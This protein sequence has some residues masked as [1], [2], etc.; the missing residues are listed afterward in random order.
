MKK[1]CS[2]VGAGENKSNLSWVKGSSLIIAADGGYSYLNNL[3]LEPD[4]LVGDFDSQ[5]QIPNAVKIKKLNIEK[6][7]TDTYC[8]IEEGIQQNCDEFRLFCCTGGRIDHTLANIQ[9]LAYL[10]QKEKRAFLFDGDFVLTAVT[11]KTPL[12]FNEGASGTI[13]VFSYNESAVGVTLNGLK[14]SIKNQRISNT[15]PLGVS[16]SFKGEKSIITLEQG[17]LIVVFPTACFELI[18]E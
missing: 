4:L 14:Y 1:I 3:G 18:I 16:N 17:V 5:N 6:D 15:F 8:C 13:S 10:A 11:P 9:T 2:I 7:E 12:S